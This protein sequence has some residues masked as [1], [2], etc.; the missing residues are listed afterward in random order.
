MKENFDFCLKRL[1]EHEGGYSNH[2]FDPGGPTKYG[3]TIYDYRLYINK[4]G[5]A[6]DVKN[7]NLD[8]AKQI[9]RSKYWDALRCDELPAGVDYCVF[10]YGVNSGIG[11]PVK[12]LQGNFSVT[13]N[14]RSITDTLLN[15]IRKA[16]P[17][18]LIIFI[19][20]ERLSF[21]RRLATWRTFGGGWGR[22]VAEVQAASL[23]LARAAAK[24]GDHGP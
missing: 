9:Y 12:L 17:I 4:N 3:I 8:Q 5:T 11:R 18:D 23:D 20:T 13:G 16:N 6:N 14:N 7:L 10:D 19:C 1:L 24:G 22:R 21:L 2:P 15:L